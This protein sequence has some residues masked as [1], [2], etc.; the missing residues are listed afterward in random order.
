M[1]VDPVQQ[2]QKMHSLLEAFQQ[3][4][5]REHLVTVDLAKKFNKVIAYANKNISFMERTVA[6]LNELIPRISE[7]SWFLEIDEEQLDGMRKII[8]LMEKLS[9]IMIRNWARINAALRQHGTGQAALKAYKDTA[10]T[11]KELSVDLNDRF[12]VLPQDED[13]QLILQ[14]L[15][16]L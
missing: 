16:D 15:N 14:E 1:V 6:D 11:L 5:V 2:H 7:L 8:E 9:A 10:N 13:F 3:A 12:F 4:A